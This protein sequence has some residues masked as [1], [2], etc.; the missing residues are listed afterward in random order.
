MER[1]TRTE[2]G[3]YLAL[4][5]AMRSEDPFRQVGA[6]LTSQITGKI[7][8]TSYNGLKTGQAWPEEWNDDKNSPDRRRKIIHAE[9]N[10][11]NHSSFDKG[12]YTLY[13]N[14]SPCESCAKLIVGQNVDSVFYIE[15]YPNCDEFKEIFKFFDIHYRGLKQ[16][17]IR[18]IIKCSKKALTKLESMIG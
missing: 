8:A 11:F 12:P 18:N 16:Q 3:C 6:C 1:L 14:Y 7:I 15:E 10:L 5:A 13:M 17:Q 9:Q 2:Y 4:S